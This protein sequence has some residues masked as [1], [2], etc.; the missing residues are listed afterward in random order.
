LLL[1]Y[2]SGGIAQNDAQN[3]FL[4]TDLNNMIDA[5]Y[6]K[7]PSDRFHSSIKPYLSFGMKEA[8]DSAFHLTNYK[9]KNYFLYNEVRA[10]PQ[11]RNNFAVQFLPQADAQVGYD[12][13]RAKPLTETSGGMYSRID[14]NRDFSADVTVIGG[15]VSYPGFMDTSVSTTKVIPGL[16]ALMAIITCIR[17][18]IFPGIFLIL[19]CDS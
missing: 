9:I 14:I 15:Q 17:L 10:N 13:L 12:V 5:Y 8:D 11:Y 19:P 4:S 1:S 16:G 18:P 3:A 6:I 7:Y 2:L